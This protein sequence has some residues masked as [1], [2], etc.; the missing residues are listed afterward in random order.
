MPDGK[1]RPIRRWSMVLAAGLV[2][3]AAGLVACGDDDDGGG[4]DTGEAAEQAAEPT[5]ESGSS[6]DPLQ[7]TLDWREQGE[8][9]S[10]PWKIAYVM[11]GLADGYLQRQKAAA[12]E[13]AERYGIELQV[14]D[15]QFNPATQVKLMQDA[16]A[17][18]FDGYIIQPASGE[19]ICG[20]VRNQLIAQ[21]K[22]VAIFN[23]PI[24]GDDDYT[25]GTVGFV[26]FQTQPYETAITMSAFELC[27]DQCKAAVIS[28]PPGLDLTNRFNAGVE[29]AKAANPNVEVVV[30]QA[31]DFNPQK[32]LKVAQDALQAHPDIDLWS[33]A[34][35][36]MTGSI[37]KAIRDAGKNPEDAIIIS[38]ACDSTGTELVASGTIDG[39]YCALP[40]QEAEY[41]IDQMVR[42]LET[43]ETTPGFVDLCE[44]PE[45]VGPD[46][47]TPDGSSPES[48][49]L[50]QENADLWTPL[51]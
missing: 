3:A 51:Y 35:D 33:S 41:P 36:Q 2:L 25:E 29:E 8:E 1:E 14:F 21:E 17:A 20:M 7:A 16:L 11:V 28:G 9:A 38:E 18:D 19:A 45:V 46:G 12:E 40:V 13:T 6:D 42:F 50:T 31:A 49:L 22:P 24:C 27:E 43:G 5:G 44:A 23:N 39:S 10:E 15:S 4:G 47:I 26:G 48:C 32:A 34:D 37:V 30:E